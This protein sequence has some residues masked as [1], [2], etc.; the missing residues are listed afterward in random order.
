MWWCA[1]V[2]C[3]VLLRNCSRLGWT[4]VFG[5]Q[6]CAHLTISQSSP[7]SAPDRGD[8]LSKEFDWRNVL[9]V[10]VPINYLLVLIYQCLSEWDTATHGSNLQHAVAHCN[11]VHVHGCIMIVSAVWMSHVSQIHESCRKYECVMSPTCI[12]AWMNPCECPRSIWHVMS[13]TW[14]SHASHRHESCHAYGCVMAPTCI[15]TWMCPRKASREVGGWGRD[16][17]SRNFMKP[18]PRRKWYLTTGRRFH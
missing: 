8:M 10:M 18:T 7:R 1:A 2:F 3:S 9:S 15:A 17:F 12:A 13:P 5:S 11:N 14:G 16:P 6:L 4:H